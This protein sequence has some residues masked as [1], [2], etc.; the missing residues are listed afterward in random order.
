VNQYIHRAQ[1]ELFDLANDP[2]ET[3][4]LA[5]EEDYADLLNNMKADLK[6]FQRQTKDPWISKW[7]Y[8]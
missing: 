4:N 5:L 3:R 6:K 7:E 8:E 2:D 1:F